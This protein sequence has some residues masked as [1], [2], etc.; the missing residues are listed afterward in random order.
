MNSNLEFVS[1]R[2]AKTFKSE[3]VGLPHLPR[4][5]GTC[6]IMY[7]KIQ[8]TIHKRGLYDHSMYG[9]VNPIVE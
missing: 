1:V 9:I 3:K 7:K 6:K 5:V 4:Y 8:D 2:S